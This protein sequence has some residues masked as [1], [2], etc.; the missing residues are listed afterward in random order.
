[1]LQCLQPPSGAVLTRVHPPFHPCPLP[2]PCT[3]DTDPLVLEKHICFQAVWVCG[4]G[5]AA[6]RAFVRLPPDVGRT[7]HETTETSGI[8]IAVNNREEM[9]LAWKLPSM[10]Q[11][12]WSKLLRCQQVPVV[13]S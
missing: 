12:L 1:M 11:N 8:L 4:E 3:E 5:A 2:R 10:L 9:R 6:T 7:A 13:M